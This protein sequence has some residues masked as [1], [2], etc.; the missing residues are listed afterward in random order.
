MD[1]PE[2]ELLESS[3]KSKTERGSEADSASRHDERM[4]QSQNMQSLLPMKNERDL[5]FLLLVKTTKDVKMT[6][7]EEHREM[8]VECQEIPQYFPFIA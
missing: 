3:Y 6:M 4:R 7:L 2:S 8:M 1:S 5:K